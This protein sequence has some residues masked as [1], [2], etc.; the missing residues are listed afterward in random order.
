MLFEYGVVGFFIV[1]I[2]AIGL[3]TFFH[4]EHT[5]H[6]IGE[7]ASIAVLVV[8]AILGVGGLVAMLPW[9]AL[10]I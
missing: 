2:A 10:N 9:L 6:R 8:V 5:G 4:E 3:T 7:A 1:V